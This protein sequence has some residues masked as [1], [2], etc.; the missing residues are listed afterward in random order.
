MELLKKYIPFP[1]LKP[2][3]YA[4]GGVFFMLHINLCHGQQAQSIQQ[5][6][7]QTI[8]SYGVDLQE[9]NGLGSTN[10]HYQWSVLEAEFNGE[11]IEQTPSGNQIE[12]DWGDSPA[13]FY[14]LLVQEYDTTTKCEAEPRLLQVEIKGMEVDLLGPT[15]LCAGENASFSASY[16]GGTWS[17]E[18]NDLQASISSQGVFT[19]QA[20]GTVQVSYQLEVDDCK[21]SFLK[22]VEVLPLPTPELEDGFVC[23]DALGNVSAP[24]VLDT[25]YSDATHSATWWYQGSLLAHSSNQLDVTELGTYTV[26][27]TDLATG[28]TSLPVNAQV[29]QGTRIIDAYATVSEDF[30]DQQT[31]VVHVQ[32]NG[33]FQYRIVGGVFQ[34]SNVFHVIGK[35]ET[36]TIEIRAVDGCDVKRIEATVI[37]YP[38]FF[39]PNTDGSNDLWNIKSLE[40]DRSAS[41]LIF[42]RYGKFLVEIRPFKSGWDGTY[43]GKQMP[44][45][46]YWFLVKY[47]DRNNGRP[48]E[49][50]ANFTLKR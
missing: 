46:D 8:K 15:Q 11:I 25:G 2:W 16:S 12:I 40:E 42:D 14:T 5:I 47:K 30:H 39:T 44:S 48:R 17:L 43:N 10:S 20:A 34:D 18:A 7:G 32:G 38:K 36:Y 50:R 41:I 13:G 19:A 23:F 26:T 24:A 22:T 1:N 28:C 21:F 37:N 49:F 33:D 29:S 4:I 3:L 6:C 27:V 31:I 9:N 45:N 35:G